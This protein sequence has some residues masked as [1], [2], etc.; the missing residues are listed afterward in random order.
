MVTRCPTNFLRASISE[1]TAC[2]G[3]P[4][5]SADRSTARGLLCELAQFRQS[6]WVLTAGE[7]PVGA[8]RRSKTLV[9][10]IQID[11]LLLYL[12]Q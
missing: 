2:A 3:K 10:T 6:F 12:T 9:R 8:L 4:R 1:R 7:G 5:P 11:G